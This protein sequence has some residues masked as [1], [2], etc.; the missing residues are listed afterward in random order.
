[1]RNRKEKNRNEAGFTLI[2]MLVTVLIV[3]VL[4]AMAATGYIGYVR[5]AKTAEGKALL[6]SLWTSLQGCAQISPG[7]A[8]TTSSQFGRI[9]VSAAG[10]TG[11]GRWTIA[12]G[13]ATF[14]S[15]TNVYTLSAPLTAT[16]QAGKDVAGIVVNLS[17]LAS[18]SPPGS[19][20]CTISGTTST[21]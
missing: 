17:Y 11:D 21:C 20:S 10:L 15:A 18:N 5:D 13:D 19:F 7:T 9:G 1:M 14:V 6:G 12:G 3:G 8:C 16:G 4:A 2:E